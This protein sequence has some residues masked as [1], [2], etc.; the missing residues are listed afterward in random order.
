MIQQHLEDVLKEPEL[1][2]DKSGQKYRGLKCGLKFG[3]DKMN[4]HLEKALVGDYLLL[5]ARKCL[6]T[7]ALVFT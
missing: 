7:C 1:V 2:K 5:S 3:L 4:I 6:I